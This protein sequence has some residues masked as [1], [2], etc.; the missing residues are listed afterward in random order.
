MNELLLIALTAAVVNNLVLDRHRADTAHADVRGIDAALALAAAAWSALLLATAAVYG[1]TQFWLVALGAEHFGLLL[2]L[3]ACAVATT[4]IAT[5]ARSAAPRLRC[6][7]H[8]EAPLVAASSAML[9]IAVQRAASGGLAAHLLAA[10][11]AGFVFV[12]AQTLLAGLCERLDRA[13]IPLP[14]RGPP[15]VLA[16]AGLLSLA[17]LGFTGIAGL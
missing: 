9:G 3:A 2:L 5:L 16:T 15:I 7:L 1:V 8:A 17:F 11:G 14:F 6:L 10:L 13:D 12:T 4:L